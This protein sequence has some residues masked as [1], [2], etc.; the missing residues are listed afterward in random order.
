MKWLLLRSVPRLRLLLRAL[1]LVSI[2]GGVEGRSAA[3]G[4]HCALH[5]A[6]ASGQAG[7]AMFEA[8]PPP[9]GAATE[10]TK[11]R[12]AAH[13]TDNGPAVAS[14]GHHC[15]HCPPAECATALPCASGPSSQSAPSAG[16]AMAS[17]AARSLRELPDSQR[18]G[19]VD[20]A[21]PTPPPQ[22]AA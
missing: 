19:S 15:P 5:S 9:A 1:M 7:M 8:S 2:I 13:H 17:F 11:H 16:P 10:L 20:H 22:A 3:L 14:S 4:A 6:G 18:G 12:I 21:P